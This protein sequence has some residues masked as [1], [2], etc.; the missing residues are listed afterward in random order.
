[1]YHS[2]VS[3]FQST[4]LREGRPG[5]C[6]VCG[7]P[8]HVSI[9]APARGATPLVVPADHAAAFQSTPL[10]EGRLSTDRR[11]SNDRCFNPRPCARGDVQ[12]GHGLI[13]G[14]PFQSTPLREGRPFRWYVVL[15]GRPFQSTPLREGRLALGGDPRRVQPVSIHAPARGATRGTPPSP[16][17]LR[18]QSTPLREGRHAAPTHHQRAEPRFN[19]R[20]CARGDGSFSSSAISRRMVSIHAPARGATRV[21]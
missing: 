17:N 3:S 13:V 15:D 2:T 10:R 8:T 7:S 11:S 4:P 12:R 6:P 19:P 5:R 20:P 1:M 18:F 16:S 14:L 21:S 9:H